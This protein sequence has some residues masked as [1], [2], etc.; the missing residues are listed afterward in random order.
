MPELNETPDINVITTPNVSIYSDTMTE[1]VTNSLYN[2]GKESLSVL[3][4]ENNIN[5]LDKIHSINSDQYYLDSSKISS[6]NE[7]TN[8]NSDPIKTLRSIRLSNINR[9]IIG[10][11]NINSLRNK[12]EAL[13][14]IVCGNLDILVISETKLDESFPIEQFRMDGYLPPFRADRDGVGGVVIIYVRDDIPC[15][16]KKDHLKL[17]KSEGIFLELNLRKKRLLFGG[18]NHNKNNTVEF[19]N[20]I[21]PILVL[22][23]SKYDNF[24][25]LGD[26]NSEM[27]ENDMN[28]F[29]DTYNLRNLIKEPTCLKT[30]I[31]PVLL[32]LF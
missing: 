28:G 20:E 6:L 5:N 32:T 12:F 21:G 18:Y 17:K 15:I 30:L 1:N 8:E 26:F 25:I 10:H 16:E 19:L 2:L 29:C 9:L 3:Q 14:Y 7:S 22:Y 27:C 31:I 23:M 11:L 4:T 13:K 24:I